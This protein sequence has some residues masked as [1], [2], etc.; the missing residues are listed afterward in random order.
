ME[1]LNAFIALFNFVKGKE[2]IYSHKEMEWLIQKPNIWSYTTR[3]SFF[4]NPNCFNAM[5]STDTPSPVLL[6]FLIVS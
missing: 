6:N 5:L 2:G 3:N 1:C 4:L